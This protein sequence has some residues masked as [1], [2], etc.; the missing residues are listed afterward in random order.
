M[1]CL[2]GAD[3]RQITVKLSCLL[4]KLWQNPSNCSYYCKPDD[5]NDHRGL[6]NVFLRHGLVAMS[7]CGSHCPLRVW[8]GGGRP[9]SHR[10]QS[11]DAIQTIP[12]EETSPRC[13][14]RIWHRIAKGT[15]NSFGKPR[16]GLQIMDTQMGFLCPFTMWRLIEA[17]AWTSK[18]DTRV[19]W[20]LRHHLT[21]EFDYFSP[22]FV[23]KCIFTV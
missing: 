4:L 10:R 19:S 23:Q 8:G 16:R 13:N 14:N 1:L 17:S 15:V 9:W 20:F 5:N 3:D 6:F 12:L 7:K 11:R 2:N 21:I 22:I 18:F